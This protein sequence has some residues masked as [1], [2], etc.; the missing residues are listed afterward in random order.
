MAMQEQ[1]KGAGEIL[2]ATE[3]IVEITSQIK[4]TMTSQAKATEEFKAAL[5]SLRDSTASL[6]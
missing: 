3:E 2:K 1:D 6:I 5:I 4:T